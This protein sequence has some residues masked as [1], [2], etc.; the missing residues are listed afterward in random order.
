MLNGIDPIFIFTFYKL[1]TLSTE[2]LAAMPLVAQARARL[3]LPPIPVYLSE[4]LTGVYIDSEEKNIDIATSTQTLTD[5]ESPIVDQK[6]IASVVSINLKASRNSIGMT[7]LAALSDVIFKKV[8]S[9]EYS[10]TYLHG[11]VTIFNG[12]LHSFSISQGSDN[13][14][15]D[16]K[17]ELSQGTTQAAAVTEVAA[18]PGTA[19]LDSGGLITSGTTPAGSSFS[20]PVPTGGMP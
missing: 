18:T 6:G 8:T 13:N 4:S 14:L 9:K 19:S 7:L 10:V 15:Y 11:A 5:G 16:I 2:E 1:V 12:L 3:A 17:I 20:N